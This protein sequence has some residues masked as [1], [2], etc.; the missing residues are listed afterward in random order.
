MA[1]E[2]TP[3]KSKGAKPLV[4]FL[5]GLVIVILAS[6][7]VKDIPV[8]L[9]GLE[10]NLGKTLAMVGVFLMLLPVIDMFYVSPLRT[11]IY[12]R[13]TNLENTFS[14]AESLKQ[15]M[16]ELRTSYDQKLA[17]AEAEA[18][19]QIQAAINEAN[20]MKAQILAEA[21]SQADE[22][23][24]RVQEDMEREKRKMLV[25]L[26]THVVDLTLTATEKLIGQSMDEQKQ[27][28]LVAQFI[29]N[30]EVGA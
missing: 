4:T 19:E 15:R 6:S 21:K 5:I 18:R 14:E 11:A 27:R 24:S 3:T 13:N 2:A 8:P 29:E 10:L 17:A 7:V 30:A 1:T 16:E 20:A 25:E 22:L 26:R 12:E 9:P 28:Q 23:R